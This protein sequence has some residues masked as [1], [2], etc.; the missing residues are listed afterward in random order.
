MLPA[1]VFPARFVSPESG[2]HHP[3]KAATDREGL[4]HIYVWRDGRPVE[5]AVI[6]VG[7][8]EAMPSAT[9]RS[10]QW[11]TESG[12]RL[13]REGGCGCGDPLKMWRPPLVLAARG[14]A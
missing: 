9:G 13:S 1:V 2:T 5:L 12:L 7:D 3:V 8:W 14:S 4:T 6:P 11:A 10:R